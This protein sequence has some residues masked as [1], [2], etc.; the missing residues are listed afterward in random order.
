MIEQDLRPTPRRD[1]QASRWPRRRPVGYALNNGNLPSRRNR[2][3]GERAKWS[4][5][6]GNG[7][8]SARTVVAR[9]MEDDLL[10]L[11]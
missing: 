5:H 6:A 2:D 10:R 9:G 3:R 8:R 1:Q 11:P 4:Q 7:G